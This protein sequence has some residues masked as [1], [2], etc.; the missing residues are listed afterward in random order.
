M[1]KFQ[2]DEQRRAVL[3]SVST[4]QPMVAAEGS[5]GIR[6]VRFWGCGCQ[7]SGLGACCCIRLLLRYAGYRLVA[8]IC[9]VEV[10]GI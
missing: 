1:K 2:L 5:G 9:N 6:G 3:V 10:P 8:L 7:R 4:E